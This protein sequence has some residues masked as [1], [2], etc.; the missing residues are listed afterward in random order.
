MVSLIHSLLLKVEKPVMFYD[1]LC[2]Q[3]YANK[4]NPKDM[5]TRKFP[6]K[7]LKLF[8]DLVDACR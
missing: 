6:R 4:E 2:I 8:L 3:K 5:V 1:K 7:K